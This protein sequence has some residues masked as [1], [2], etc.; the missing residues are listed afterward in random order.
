VIT[1]GFDVRK[2]CAHSVT[3]ACISANQAITTAAQMIA[4]HQIDCAIAGGVDSLSDPPIRVTRAFRKWLLKRNKSKTMAQKLS[5]NKFFL[6]IFLSL[7]FNDFFDTIAKKW[8]LSFV[9]Q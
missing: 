1:S 8:F 3:M 5:K 4:N 6:F 7:Y 2:T 9:R